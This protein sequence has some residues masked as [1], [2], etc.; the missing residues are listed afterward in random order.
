VR[1]L[2]DQTVHPGAVSQSTFPSVGPVDPK[3][4]F[5]APKLPLSIQF[6]RVVDGLGRNFAAEARQ[7]LIFRNKPE[8]FST[9]TGTLRLLFISAGLL[10]IRSR[11]ANLG[12]RTCDVCLSTP[13]QSPFRLL[14]KPAWFLASS[15]KIM[16]CVSDNISHN[17]PSAV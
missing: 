7:S 12:T 13:I 17:C 3:L 5:S 15:R 2:N 6:Q 16:P 4:R 14:K 9:S 11:A 10:R 8:D 1:R